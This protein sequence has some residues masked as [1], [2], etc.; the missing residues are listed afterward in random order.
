MAFDATPV[1]PCKAEQLSAAG[2]GLLRF[3]LIQINAAPI[4]RFQWEK[5]RCKLLRTR[6]PRL[7]LCLYSKSAHEAIGMTEAEYAQ[8]LDELDRL[9]NDPTIPMDPAKVWSLLADITE[10]F[11]SQ[12]KTSGPALVAASGAR[13]NRRRRDHATAIAKTLI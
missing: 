7:V 10:H 4:V 9:L 1:I 2:P 5:H 12:P 13:E 11:V 3:A 8:T 6:H